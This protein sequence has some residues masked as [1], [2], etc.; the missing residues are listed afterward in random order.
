MPVRMTSLWDVRGPH[1]DLAAE[2]YGALED[3]Y[4]PYLAVG[5]LDRSPWFFT[6]S[7]NDAVQ[8][9]PE[10]LGTGCPLTLDK[11]CCSEEKILMK[12]FL[13]NEGTVRNCRIQIGGVCL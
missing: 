1:K 12:F 7:K 9:N 13:I 2:V 5:L 10:E 4:S 11:Y 8:I 6:D 3:A